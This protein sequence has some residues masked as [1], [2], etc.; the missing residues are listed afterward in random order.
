MTRLINICGIPH[1]IINVKDEFELNNQLGVIDITKCIIRINSELKEGVYNE[2]VCH[3]VLH[4]ILTHL[5]YDDL[6]GDEHFVSVIAN[7]INQSFSPKIQ[8]NQSLSALIRDVKTEDA[9]S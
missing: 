5:G 4:G 2:T 6:S 1:E 9:K 8:V 3:E 7:A